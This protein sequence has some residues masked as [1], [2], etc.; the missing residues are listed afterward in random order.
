[1]RLTAPGG[2][3]SAIPG[4]PP[5]PRTPLTGCAFAA[6]CPLATDTCRETPP[7]ARRAPG[8]PD[9]HAA[10]HHSA[11]LADEGAVLDV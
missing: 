11:R 1:P 7:E 3:L 8:R 9:H 2:R 10:C 4:R 6:R 5:D